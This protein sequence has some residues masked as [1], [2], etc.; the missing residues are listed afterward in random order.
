M[1]V[2]IFIVMRCVWRRGIRKRFR[3]FP[4]GFY[5]RFLNCVDLLW[6]R[7]VMHTRI[8]QKMHWFR[9]GHVT[10]WLGS[11]NSRRNSRNGFRRCSEDRFHHFWVRR[12]WH[13]TDVESEGHG[14]VY[15][16][17]TCHGV[18]HIMFRMTLWVVTEL[19]A[20]GVENFGSLKGF[21]CGRSC[22]W[23]VDWLINQS[24]SS[25]LGSTAE[26]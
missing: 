20:S 5:C 26:N 12:Q 19:A 17:P 6:Q 2:P 22:G 7:L 18:H 10:F 8:K 11:W 23:V 16:C 1:K 25:W 24:L 4:G 21:M 15:G 9:S 14:Y 13:F 3:S